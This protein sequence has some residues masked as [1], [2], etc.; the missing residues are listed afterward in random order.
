MRQTLTDQFDPNLTKGNGS[1]L[2]KDTENDGRYV[3]SPVSTQ[4]KYKNGNEKILS[5]QASAN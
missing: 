2:N 3:Y 5:D 1:F 4:G